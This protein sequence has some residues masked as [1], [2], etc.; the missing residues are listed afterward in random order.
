V[1]KGDFSGNEIVNN[2]VLPI[3]TLAECEEGIVHS[4]AGGEGLT[5]R[6][7]GMGIVSGMKIK[8]LRNI[9]RLIIVHASG[10]RVALG[11]GEAHKIL[12]TKVHNKSQD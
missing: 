5:S 9:G 7:A 2:N 11:R 8:V 10:T 4:L 6:L 12:V 1:S 3:T